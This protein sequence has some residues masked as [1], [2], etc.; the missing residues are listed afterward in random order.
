MIFG[1]LAIMLELVLFLDNRSTRQCM[2]PIFEAKSK[3][4]N[5]C[6]FSATFDCYDHFLF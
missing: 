3:F 4:Q 2:W 1:L 5:F 6:V